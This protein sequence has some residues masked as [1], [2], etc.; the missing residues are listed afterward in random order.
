MQNMSWLE[1]I[2]YPYQLFRIGHAGGYNVVVIRDPH[3]GWPDPEKAIGRNHRLQF[4]VQ[5]PTV[6]GGDAGYEDA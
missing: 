5:R 1:L 3:V 4:L 6:D 2:P